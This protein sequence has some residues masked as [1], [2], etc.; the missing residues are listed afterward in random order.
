LKNSLV[1]T[2][3]GGYNVSG[4]TSAL[5]S[6]TSAANRAT[7]AF[8]TLNENASFIAPTT[9]I[10]KPSSTKTDYVYLDKNGKVNGFTG[11]SNQV[12]KDGGLKIEAFSK[13]GVVTKDD[14]NILKPIAES[15]GEDTMVAV[16]YG[17]SILTKEQRE[18]LRQF[19]EGWNNNRIIKNAG[20]ST[21]LRRQMDGIYDFFGVDA[22]Q[23]VANYTQP[24]FTAPKL[25]EFVQRNTQPVNV[26]FDSFMQVN[27]DI[28]DTNHF[29]KQVEKIA[30]NISDKKVNNLV[31]KMY[32]RM[33][34]H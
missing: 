23:F 32:D 3:E 26:H 19:A 21:L 6:I 11:K 1:S 9:P 24:L 31:N 7:D 30:G 2:L 5:N 29:T 18:M 16:K 13:G 15:V 4:I 34:Y 20:D 12:I 27:G 33:M 22:S 8:R 10:S 17:E 14:D 25:P 28:N